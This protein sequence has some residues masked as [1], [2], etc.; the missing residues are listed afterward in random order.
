MPYLTTHDGTRLHYTSWGTGQPIIFVHGWAIP[1]D[2]WEYQIPTMVAAGFRCI[3][4]DNRGCG[5]SEQSSDGYDLDTMAS[6]LHQV[7]ERQ[8]LSAF[9]LVGF[10]LGGGVIARYLKLFGSRHVS[11]CVLIACSTPYLL[12]SDDNPEG[13][14]ASAVHDSFLAG[15]ANDRPQLLHAVAPEFFGVGLPGITVS[16]EMVQWIIN[17]CLQA[18]ARGMEEVY[19]AANWTDQREDMVSFTMPTLIIHGDSDPFQPAQFTAERTAR[20]IPG[21]RLKLYENASHGLFITHRRQLSSDL[22][23]FLRSEA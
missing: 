9:S 13:I 7:V 8:Q 4:F 15:M 6:D 3:V 16:P 17:L 20:A 10:S 1:S 23:R 2:M 5:R 22:Q 19:K 12:K 21:S 18:S 11:R 14:E